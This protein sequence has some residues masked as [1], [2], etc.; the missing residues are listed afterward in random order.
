MNTLIITNNSGAQFRFTRKSGRLLPRIEDGETKRYT[1]LTDQ[2]IED[3]S[4]DLQRAMDDSD[5]AVIHVDHGRGTLRAVNGNLTLDDDLSIGTQA[6]PFKHV[7][8]QG[9]VNI[10]EGA[11]LI[12]DVLTV[13]GELAVAVGAT[14]ILEATTG[15]VA[16]GIYLNAGAHELRNV[17]TSQLSV[18][19][20]ALTA[21]RCVFRTNTTVGAAGSLTERDC[22][23]EGNLTLDNAITAFDSKGGKVFGTYTPGTSL[24]KTIDDTP[25]DLTP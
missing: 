5:I 17:V 24:N 22:L 19:G 4:A 7:Q 13:T 10:T 6:R 1:D 21:I 15:Y 25:T 16:D 12:T 9:D 8:V 14:G 2:Q 11:N 18:I 23:F 3:W 20:A